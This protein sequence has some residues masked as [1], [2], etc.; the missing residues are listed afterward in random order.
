MI[1][2]G[3]SRHS[4]HFMEHKYAYKPMP[5]VPTFIQTNSV[6]TQP[7]YCFKIQFHI[8]LPS[9]TEYSRV[10]PF[11]SNYASY[12]PR[13]L[14]MPDL[15]FPTTRGWQKVEYVICLLITQFCD[16]LLLHSTYI[17]IY[18]TQFCDL[19]LLHYI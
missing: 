6:H 15:T 8:I 16:L 13:H 3:K 18:I 9:T 19:L 4:L 2:E 17:Y 11:H 5:P 7:P 10:G 12:M 14:I 1:P